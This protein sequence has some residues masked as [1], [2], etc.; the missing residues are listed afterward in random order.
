VPDLV[1]VELDD[2]L[3]PWPERERRP[4]RAWTTRRWAWIATGLAAVLAAVT[5]AGGTHGASRTAPSAGGLTSDLTVARHELW[6]DPGAQLVGAVGDLVLVADEAGGL[7]ALAAQDGTE[8]W[9]ADGS[10]ALTSMDGLS[11]AEVMG[12][13]A[14]LPDVRR[15]RVICSG[16]TSSA[17]STR[18]LDPASGAVLAELAKD[19]TTIGGY[20]V[21]VQTAFAQDGSPVPSAVTVLSAADGSTLWSR[22]LSPQDGT[23]DW[24]L[25]PNAL[26]V[27]DGSTMRMVD[28]ATGEVSGPPDEGVAPLLDVAL[29]DGRRALTGW[30]ASGRLA[31]VVLDADGRELW[32]KDSVAAVPAAV[33]DDAA[34][35]VVLALAS[36]GGWAAFDGGTGDQLWTESTQAGFPRVH[37]AGVMVPEGSGGAVRDDRTGDVLWTIADAEGALPAS[38]GATLLLRDRPSGD[39]VVRDLRTGR[40]VARYPLPGV[41]QVTEV[42]DVLALSG[43]RLAVLTT[44][45]LTVLAPGGGGG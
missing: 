36:G 17:P 8:V 31:F 30:R 2:E 11:A 12:R 35:E 38:D 24:R 3:D 23:G 15:A 7:R 33:R 16:G 40:E 13:V 39:M 25:T 45:G 41:G 42:D 5:V 28:L 6:S 22:D 1:E 4:R 14:A 37:V 32:S 34:G 20:L 26:I 29:A 43:G 10:C 44:A 19:Y 27:T 9:R 18:V 21:Y